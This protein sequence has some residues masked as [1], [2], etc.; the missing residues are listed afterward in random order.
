[1]ARVP[2]AWE[3]SRAQPQRAAASQDTGKPDLELKDVTWTCTWGPVAWD[4]SAPLVLLL[5]LA[6][7]TGPW[8]IHSPC[9]RCWAA[10]P[11]ELHTLSY[12]QG[13][14]I[15]LTQSRFVGPGG[16]SPAL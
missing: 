12:V 5:T 3:R 13:L 2:S 15:N 10:L 16:R 11:S 8:G 1:M 7:H 6:L 14:T 9:S 4:V